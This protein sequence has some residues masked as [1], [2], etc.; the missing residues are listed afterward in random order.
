MSGGPRTP[1]SFTSSAE[2]SAETDNNMIFA[3]S[4]A[5]GSGAAGRAQLKRGGSGGTVVWELAAVQAGGDSVE[6]PDGIVVTDAYVT[7]TG[8]GCVASLAIG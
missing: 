6:F 8:A 3:F 7:I 2:V 1:V 4:I 5:A